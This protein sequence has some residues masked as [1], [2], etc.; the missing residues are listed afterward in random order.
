MIMPSKDTLY[1]GRKG[2]GFENPSYFEKAKDL[3]PSLYDEKVIVLGYTL[4]FLTHF[5]E[6]L[7]IKK[8]KR[9]KENKIEFAYDYG[10]KIIIDLEDEVVSLLE[11]E[12]ENLKTIESLKSN[13]VKTG[14]Q[15]S[16]KVEFET[17][18]K[19]E[20]DCQEIEKVCDREENLNVITPGMFKLSV[21]QSVLPIFVTKMSCA[22]NG[23]KN[24]DTLSSVR[25]PK[26][27]GV[28][29]MRKGV[30]NTVKADLSSVNHFNLNKKVKRYSRKNLMAYNNSKTWSAFDCNNARNALCNAR[31]NAFVDVNALFVFMI[32]V[33]RWLPKMQPLAEPIAKWIPK[34]VHI[35]LWIIDSGCLKHMAGNSALLTNFVETFLGTVRFGNNDFAVI[36]GYGDVKHHK[37]KMA[38]DSNKPLYL[39]HIDL[40]GPMRVESINGKRYVLVVVDD[41]SRYTLEFFLHSK[42]EASDVKISF[43]K[44]TQ[45]NLQLQVQR[46]PTD[47]GTKFKNKTLAKFFDEVCITQQ[48]SAARTSQQNGIVERRNRTLVEAARTMLTFANLPLFLWA[49]AIATARFTQNH[50]IFL[51]TMRMLESSRQKGDIRAFVG[52]SKESAAIRIDNKGTC[53]I[54]ESVNVNFNE[55]SEMASK[56]FSLEPS[57]SKLNETRKSSN[58]AVLQVLVPRPEGKTI[59]KTKWIFKNKKDKSSLVIRNKARLVAVGYSQQEGI[60]YDETFAP[61]ARIEAIRLFL[62][63]AAHKYFI[64]FQMDVKTAFL[65]GIVKVEVYVGQPPGFVS[66]QY[67]DYVYALNK[68]L[69]GLKQAPRACYDVLSHP[70]PMVEQAKLKH[71]LVGKPVDHT[72][73]QTEA[74]QADCDVKATNIILRALPLEIYALVSTHKVAKDLWERIQMLMQGTSLTKQEKE[75]KLYDAFDK[76]AYQKGETLLN[77][78]FLNTLPPK[79]SKFVTDVKLV[80]D[81][82]TTNVD[83]L[84]AY[85]GQHK[86]HA[87]E[88]RLMHELHSD[89][90]ALISQHQLNR[91]TCQHHQQ[92]YHQPQF[93]QQASTYQSS[94]YTTLYHTPQFVSQGSSSSNL[95]ISY[96]MNDTSSTVNHNAYM[97]LA[98]RIDYAPITHHPSEFSSPETG[99]VVS[100]FQK[101]DDPIDVINHMMSFLTSVVTS[102]YPATNNQLRTSFNH[103]QQATINDGRVTIQP[104]QGRQNHMSAGLSRPFA[105]GTGGTSGRQRVLQEEELDFLADPGTTE[106]STNQTSVTTNAAY[107]ADDLDAYDSDC[108]ELNSAKVALMA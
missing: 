59:I 100:V 34:I 10:K 45:V 67:P 75:C 69:Y 13:Y 92:S 37:S 8:F 76:F 18:N 86:Y 103:L 95:S 41:Y 89:P 15:S 91:P 66:K 48:F 56:Q 78:K 105:S 55:I 35:C 50:V 58:P 96:P 14:V 84:H 29:W 51:M 68:A 79:W 21:S 19:S 31:M 36:A 72:D 39:L 12:K 47:N 82:H 57:L 54:H 64:V 77:T 5:D 74:I 16:E 99:L 80:R 2:I 97:T 102:R 17:K 46:V 7:E 38:F 42:D 104:I 26:P 22:S 81:L 3:R 65:N 49:E 71:D 98:P 107:Q 52:Y 73:Y 1:N 23:V 93:Q 94:P 32:T 33:R 9:A 85:L 88:V 106:S 63:Y 62:A 70:T 4:M 6:I 28:M 53:N 101:G 87:N 27:S 24:L 11:K 30:S 40:C 108:D 60:D 43:I 61:V 44:K 20:N 90:L 83:Q 25:R